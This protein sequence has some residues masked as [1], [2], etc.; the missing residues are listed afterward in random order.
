MHAS[1]NGLGDLEDRDLRDTQGF[2]VFLTLYA[3]FPT[4][5]ASDA[6]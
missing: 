2:G 1:L 3:C 6:S 4:Q 5:H